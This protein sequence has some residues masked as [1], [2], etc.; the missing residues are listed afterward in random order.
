MRPSPPTSAEPSFPPPAVT[1]PADVPPPTIPI[2]VV[3][4]PD[5][6][7]TGPASPIEPPKNRAGWIVAAVLG[8][9]VVALGALAAILTGGGDEVVIPATTVPVATTA[10]RADATTSSAP[11]STEP[12]PPIGDATVADLARS[13]VQVL[14]LANGTPVCTGS[15]TFVAADGTILTNAHVIDPSGGCGHDTIGIAVT[16]DAGEPPSLAFTAT[17]FAV[18]NVLD[19]AVIRIT[20]TIDGGA[21]DES[22]PAVPIGDSDAVEIG[23]RIRILGY[24]GIGGETVTFTTGAVSGFTSQANLGERSWIKTDATI[25]GG[26]SGGAAFDD[27]GRLIGIPTQAAASDDSPI[28][29]CRVIADTNGD[30]IR[31]DDDQCVPIGGFLNGIRPINLAAD[32]LVAAATAEPIGIDAVA[33]TDPVGYDPSQVRV[34][35]PGWSLGVSEDPDVGSTFVVT[36][37]RQDTSI[38]VWFDW[39]GIPDGVEWDGV[40]L[41]DGEI[42]EGY[43]FFGESWDLGETGVDSWMCA[44]DEDGLTP[45]VYEF[46]FYIEEDIVFFESIRITE[47]PVPVFDV[48]FRNDLDIIACYVFVAPLGSTDTGLDELGSE[49]VIQPGDSFTLSVPEGEVIYDVYDCDFELLAADYEGLA[50]TGDLTIPIG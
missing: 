40:W 9:L 37:S 14:L 3:S 1:P 31:N 28:V 24:P 46:L 26:N 50:V 23:D 33:D 11:D 2:P 4:T 13:T 7:S 5:L 45:G 19:L 47:Q 35:N 29:D 16:D 22:F 48:T 10:P 36:A 32:L 15:G 49:D 20:G 12:P 8:L 38:C 39:S 42:N 25:A 21:V 44:I 30:G 43:S 27:A 17:A 18:D 34:F 41:V 6:G